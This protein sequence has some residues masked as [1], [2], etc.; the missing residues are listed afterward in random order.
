MRIPINAGTVDRSLRLAA[1]AL[2]LALMAGGQIG[3][4]GWLGLVPLLTGL[5]GWCPLYQ[6]LGI[7]TGGPAPA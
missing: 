4:W 3:A 5:V 2:L 6:V 1:G 7:R